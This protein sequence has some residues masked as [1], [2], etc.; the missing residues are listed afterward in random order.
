MHFRL[1]RLID[2]ENLP[3][4]QHYQRRIPWFPACPSIH[5]AIGAVDDMWLELLQYLFTLRYCKISEPC[6]KGYTEKENKLIAN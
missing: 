4:I 3:I 6:A 5:S 1:F 2:Y